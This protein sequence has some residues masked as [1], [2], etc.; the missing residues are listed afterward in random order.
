MTGGVISSATDVRS[1][2]LLREIEEFLFH[3][4]RLLDERRFEDWLALFA[5]DGMYWVPAEPDQRSPLDRLSL[6]Y[7]DK[8]L[9]DVRI[10]QIRHPRYYAQAPETRT[11]HVIGNVELGED[12]VELGEDEEAG[13]EIPVRSSFVMLEYRDDHRRVFGGEARHRLRRTGE[14]L[15]I[16]FK[17]IDI[18]DCDATHA[19]MSAPF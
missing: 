15:R 4:A 17:R 19:F 18:V 9:L 14:G 3:E 6:F 5:D 2:L 16:A 11:R 7:E 13:E 1:L 8:S 10:R 12:N